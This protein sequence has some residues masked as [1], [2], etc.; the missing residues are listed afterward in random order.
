MSPERW[1]RLREIF[2]G[3]LGREPEGVEE[4]L[5][6]QCGADAGLYSEVRHMLAAHAASGL[7]DHALVT[8][9]GSVGTV[10]A[11]TTA[12]GQGPIF[13]PGQVIAG[14]YRVIRFLS[15]GGMGEVYEAEH[16][17]LLGERIALKTLLPD[18]GCDARMIARFKQEIQLSRKITH[19]NVCRVFDLER[20]PA[21]GPPS[22]ATYFF[23]MS[24]LPGETLAARLQRQGRMSPAE[25]LPILEQMA[26]ALDAAHE[27][28]VIH[29]DLKPS[30]VMLV[31]SSGGCRAVVTDFGLARR[32]VGADERTVT[33]SAQLMGTLDYMSPELLAGAQSSV[34][35]DV[36]ALGM[37]AYK[38]ITG[39][40][41]FRATTPLGAAILRS[42]HRIPPARKRVQDL[43]PCW[44]RAL[45]RALDADP[46]RRFDRAR[47]FV[48]A[49]RG[50]SA[51]VTVKLP[52]LTRRHGFGVIAA[53]V[54]ILVALVVWRGWMQ[55]R[56]V[57]SREAMALYQTGVD[58]IHAGAYFAASKALSQA[59]KLAPQFAVAQA[60]LAEA[61]LE[62]ELSDKASQE[63]LVAHRGEGSGVSER[64]QL[65][66]DAVDL[67][68]TRDYGAAVAK[69]EQLRSLGGDDAAGQNVDLG[70]AYEKAGDPAKAI[71]AYRRAAEGP[72]HSPAAWLRLGVLYAQKSEAGK[73]DEA[74]QNAERQ[75]QNTSNLEG[76]TEVEQQRGVAANRQLRIADAAAHLEKAFETAR[77]AG[78]IQQEIRAKMQLG[79]NA[80][81]AG[82]AEKA[83]QYSREALSAAQ[84]NQMLSQAAQGMMGIGA[85]YFR[86]RDFENAG[87]YYQNALTLART[88]GTSR[89]VARSLLYLASLHDQMD[90]SP[91]AER[92]ATEALAFYR[93][94]AIIKESLQC[95]AL[96]G[97]A[98]RKQADFVRAQDS[99]QQLLDL[100]TK[101]ND[102]Q[103]MVLAHESMGSLF[104]AQE[105]FP[106]AL[107]EFRK[108]LQPPNDPEHL[109]WAQ[110]Q[111]GSLLIRLGN[112]AEGQRLLDDAAVVEGKYPALR[113]SLSL[114]RAYLLLTEEK[115]AAAAVAARAGLVANP[116]SPAGWKAILGVALA[117]SGQRRE[118][119]SQCEEAVS[120][121]RS[122]SDLHLL[123]GA[124]LALLQARVETGDRAGA[125]SIYDQMTPQLRNYPES[126]WRAVAW[127]S[128]ADAT[129]RPDALNAIDALKH[130]WGEAAFSGY[131]RRPDIA[132]LLRPL[133]TQMNANQ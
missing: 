13:S 32:A 79:T 41:P 93:A 119:I 81:L 11:A 80:V 78:N 2:D 103:Q 116:G 1:A 66:I 67:T 125:R 49:L 131:Q 102:W 44:D 133:L 65:Q 52:V 59:V 94:N 92:E 130:L 21:D 75:Y 64:D 113:A 121:A 72:T 30:N 6:A 54:L 107:V 20:H 69:Y 25:T 71:D 105:R 14:R 60:R 83:E 40:L 4:F 22:E 91:D 39:E 98:Q 123:V 95:L 85:A 112:Y 10:S 100:A 82:D 108:N 118:G 57:P 87:R 18:I 96:A 104:E 23:T 38:M 127:M 68:I 86:K 24:F 19:P 56:D 58:D 70:R 62:L 122:V 17:E 132:R 120:A 50:E 55:S 9:T 33:Q 37:T 26:D 74:F 126:R 101:S 15:R 48:N 46:R 53:A 35:S 89:L 63:M 84:A 29:R 114:D 106:E 109:A 5:R 36:Y 47:S 124:E 42:K 8:P 117:A 99:F 51:T 129:Y 31:P 110:K 97:R 43:D 76:I 61:W 88:S 12:R 90:D 28:G 111:A 115:F 7:L 45:V 34:Q 3:A 16:L 73:S 128:R 77:L 27:A